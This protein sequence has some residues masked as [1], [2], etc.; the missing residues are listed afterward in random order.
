[1]CEIN[2]LLNMS[3]YSVYTKCGLLYCVQ[4]SERQCAV[5]HSTRLGSNQ[6]TVIV[7]KHLFSNVC[8]TALD[9]L[10]FIYIVSTMSF[11]I[12]KN[13]KLQQTIF[14]CQ[15]NIFI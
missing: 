15:V 11:L 5:D 13:N 8:S 4:L 7:I 12:K 3:P 10:N 2:S 9:L 14:F 1:M 6:T